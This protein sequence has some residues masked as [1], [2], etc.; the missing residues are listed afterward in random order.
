MSLYNKN[1]IKTINQIY[2]IKGV[3]LEKLTQPTVYICVGL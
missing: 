2:K 3:K 1:K